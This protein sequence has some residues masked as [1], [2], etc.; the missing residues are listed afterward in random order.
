MDTKTNKSIGIPTKIAFERK[1][2]P[3]L[4]HE[5]KQNLSKISE[6]FSFFKL[7]RDTNPNSKN[8]AGIRRRLET[9]P[10]AIRIEIIFAKS[11]NRNRTLSS[12]SIMGRKA[13][14]VVDIA[15]K[16]ERKTVLN[17]FL[18]ISFFRFC[19]VFSLWILYMTTF[20]ESYIMPIPIPNAQKVRI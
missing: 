4:T 3:I 5:C 8:K 12:K 17:P 9:K 10:Q 6:D 1:N 7:G 16:M 13:I 19:S 15:E 18:T 11:L 20:I 14:T 2:F